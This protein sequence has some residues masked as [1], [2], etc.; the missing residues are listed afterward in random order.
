MPEELRDPPQAALDLITARTRSKAPVQHE[1]DIDWTAP[2]KFHADKIGAWIELGAV[3]A[4]Q[5]EH[6]VRACMS[7]EE[8]LATGMV[9]YWKVRAVQTAK[10]L[11]H[12]LEP[13]LGGVQPADPI[14]ARCARC[15]G[16][17]ELREDGTAVGPAVEVTCPA[18]T[19][20]RCTA[21]GCPF[22]RHP[23][24]GTLC[25][26]HHETREA[27]AAYAHEA[28]SG[29]M[30]YMLGKC[31]A[32]SEPGPE[33]SMVIPGPLVERWHRQMATEYADLP[34][35]EKASDRA[36]A[37]KILAIVRGPQEQG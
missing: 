26:L 9:I 12:A 23:Q 34:D 24:A 6:L 22:P 5:I 30:A 27:L 19:E 11:G 20:E 31:Y 7:S 16:T 32:A 29:W 28:W 14:Y 13:W 10:R 15:N 36:E 8:M 4:W 33:E 1:C 18:L 25:A 2:E 17:V 21:P 35:E 3:V 37:D